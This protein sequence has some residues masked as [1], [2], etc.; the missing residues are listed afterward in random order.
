MA[1]RASA[2]RFQLLGCSR[3]DDRFLLVIEASDKKFDANAT[4]DF[5]A[6]LGAEKLEVVEA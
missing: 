5:L 4:K 3:S 1:C 2:I 6:S